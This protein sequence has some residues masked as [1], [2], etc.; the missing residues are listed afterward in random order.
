MPRHANLESHELE[1]RLGIRSLQKGA[2]SPG[3][4][5]GAMALLTEVISRTTRPIHIGHSI[6]P[7]SLT[8]LAIPHRIQLFTVDQDPTVSRYLLSDTFFARM[9]SGL[10]KNGTYGTIRNYGLIANMLQKCYEID[11]ARKMQLHRKTVANAVR[12]ILESE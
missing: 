1:T 5:T 11:A 8:P 3:G 6:F 10:S 4:R 2:T 7:V 12:R 9:W